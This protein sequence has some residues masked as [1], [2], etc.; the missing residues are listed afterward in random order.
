MADLCHGVFVTAETSR[1]LERLSNLGDM[2]TEV[3]IDLLK[4]AKEKATPDVVQRLQDL[5]EVGGS[6]VG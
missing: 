5:N 1:H 3:F 4:R 6:V 2:P